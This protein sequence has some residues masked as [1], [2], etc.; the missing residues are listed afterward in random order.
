M[1]VLAYTTLVPAMRLHLPDCDDN[2]I[3]NML[4][5]MGRE[6]HLRTHAYEEIVTQNLVAD[7]KQYTIAITGGYE[8]VQVRRVETFTDESIAAG[9][10]D[11][12]IRTPDS[13]DL[14]LPDTIE[15]F[16]TALSTAAV[17]NGMRTRT[18][19][20]P[21][22]DINPIDNDF[23]N[24]W[25]G[26]IKAGAYMELFSMPN[27]AWS[28]DKASAREAG[29]WKLGIA[30]GVRSAYTGNTSRGLTM[31]GQDWLGRTSGQSS[32]RRDKLFGGFYNS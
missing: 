11:G 1:S 27:R 30:E 31:K 29:K 9:V 10:S 25:Q 5:I 26:V 19:L 21:T 3:L 12:V 13:Y 16:P 15:F 2:L 8:I 18:V 28:S 7:Q 6:F 24:R 17:T 14:L 20:A 23:L 32:S 4:Q 22:E